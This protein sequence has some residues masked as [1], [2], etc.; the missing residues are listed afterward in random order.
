MQDR[1]FTI[2]RDNAGFFFGD[3]TNGCLHLESDVDGDGVFPDMERHYAFSRE[4]TN[5][6]FSLISLADF[7]SLCR[8]KGLSGLERFLAD[9]GVAPTITEV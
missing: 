2:Y 7:I 4:D 9:V 8:K 6:L 1:S 3:I 5:R